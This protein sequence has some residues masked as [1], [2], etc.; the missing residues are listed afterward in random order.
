MTATRLVGRDRLVYGVKLALA[1]G[2]YYAGALRLWRRLTLERKAVVLT[3]H[4]VL[5]PDAMARTWSHPAILVARDSFERQLRL[6]R[7]QFHLL[8]PDEFTSCV[9]GERPFPPS[10]CLVTFDDGWIDTFTEAW[11]L[12]RRHGVP[13]IVFLPTRFIGGDEMFWQERLGALL[14]VIAERAAEAPAFAS[15]ARRRL[16]SHGCDGI[17]DGPPERLRQRILDQVQ[18]LKQRAPGD[19]LHVADALASLVPPERLARTTLDT[20]MN[21][22]HVREMHAAGVAFGA[23]SVTHRILPTLDREAIEGEVRGAQRAI[24]DTLGHAPSL[25]SYPNGDWNAEC[26]AAV[27]DA[28]F[29]AA[30]STAPGPVDGGTDRFAIRRINMHE[31]VTRHV[32]LFFA[33]ILGVL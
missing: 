19:A 5:E 32:P 27:R 10:S 22:D 3:Y 7:R 12:L 18:A 13:A 24:A 26:V 23:H 14:H 2:L 29:A 11:P 16:A 28:G 31:D 17:L 20:F 15:E 33:R 21:W 4:R 8:S 30:F 1:Y 6:L 9:A 25:F